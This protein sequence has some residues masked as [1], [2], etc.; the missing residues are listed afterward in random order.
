MKQLTVIT[1]LIFIGFISCKTNNN[2]V[3]IRGKVIGDL[4]ATILYTVPV[5]GICDWGITKSINTDS[6]GNFKIS[7]KVDKPSFIV[8]LA[9]GSMSFE[10]SPTIVAEPGETYDL[11][12][13]ISSKEQPFILKSNNITLQEFYN[14]LSQINPKTCVYNFNR[15]TSDMSGIKRD[16]SSLKQEEI[17]K[18]NKLAE[19]DKIS[20]DISNLI[21]ADREVYYS[22]AFSTIASINTNKFIRQGTSVPDS[23]SKFWE[24]SNALVSL[25]NMN[26]LRTKNLYDFLDLC[27]WHNI[28]NS[29][30]YSK[31]SKLRSEYRKKG[32]EHTYKLELA[33]KFFEGEILEYFTVRYIIHNSKRKKEKEFITIIEKFKENYPNS[34]FN[35]FLEPVSKGIL[36]NQNIE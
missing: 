1:F 19:E 10:S 23:I 9:K 27:Y 20:N 28:H 35:E 13:D 17:S 30:T 26:I 14:D 36:D 8:V 29:I 31:F 4:P 33:N 22:T 34:L 6:L 15:E 11:T 3:L 12:I 25:T 2:E 7:I 5:N 32:T 18:L 16:L 24:E 21:K